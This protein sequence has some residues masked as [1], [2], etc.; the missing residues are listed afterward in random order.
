MV[1]SREGLG[2]SSGGVGWWGRDILDTVGW[3]GSSARSVLEPPQ[4]SSNSRPP[5]KPRHRPLRRGSHAPSLAG[6]KPPESE[7]G[8]ETW[9]S[10]YSERRGWA[11]GPWLPGGAEQRAGGGFG[12]GPG[13]RRSRVRGGVGDWR[14][15]PG[16]GPWAEL[17]W[18]C[19]ELQGGGGGQ[20]VGSPARR[21]SLVHR[22]RAGIVG[23]CSGR[24]ALIFLCT[25]QVVSGDRSSGP[26]IPAHRGSGRRPRL[27]ALPTG[28][29]AVSLRA[30]DWA[31]PTRFCCLSSPPPEGGE[32]EAS[33]QC[34][35][36]KAPPCDPAR[37][38]CAPGPG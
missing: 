24:C 22:F 14:E 2:A 17:R 34:A 8:R 27:S 11:G 19:E 1:G 6:E 12:V 23:R 37:R 30:P 26:A 7:L 16:E 18:E 20:R 35:T 36:P 38:V 5:E 31:G 21:G 15:G 32:W 4:G 28:S 10:C 25:F 9:H 33:A 13:L 29:A 3:V